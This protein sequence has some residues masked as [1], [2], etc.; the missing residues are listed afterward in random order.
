MGSLAKICSRFLQH[1][2]NRAHTQSLVS[3]PIPSTPSYDFLI[4]QYAYDTIFI[5]KASEE[6]LLCLEGILEEFSQS[7][8]LRLTFTNRVLFI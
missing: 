7:T 2:I 8:G 4:I 6:E 5:M 3:L 1:V